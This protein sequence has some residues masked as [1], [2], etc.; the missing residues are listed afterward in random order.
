MSE[1]DQVL[2][3]EAYDD[4]YSSGSEFH[5]GSGIRKENPYDNS[6]IDEFEELRFQKWNEGFDQ[7]GQDS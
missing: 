7:A 5:M 2:L 4:G 3:K 6:G 1:F